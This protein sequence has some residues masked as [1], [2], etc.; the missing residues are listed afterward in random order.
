MALRQLT[1]SF[2]GAG[3][4]AEALCRRFREAG[5]RIGMIVSRDSAGGMKLAVDCGALWSPD[6]VFPEDTD[7]V[8]VAVPD[9]SVAGVLSSAST[10]EGTIIAHTAGSLGLEVF[11]AWMKNTGVFYPLQ[12]FTKGRRVEFGGLPFFIE[13]SGESTFEN[14]SRLSEA[15]GGR[16]F[17][18]DDE[19]RR[20][21]H[22]AA[23]FVNNFT[24]Y[25]LTAGKSI[26]GHAGLDFTL[27][28]PLIRETVDKA[29]AAGPE[30]S[31][32]GPAIRDDRGT[33]EKHIK[34]LSFSPE[35]QKLY[36]E[37]TE[38]ITAHYKK[39]EK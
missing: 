36:M 18:L 35:L 15:I 23:V 6:P 14:L 13:A 24:N 10:G 4:V 33:I 7:I 30:V 3:K 8:I 5:L 31:Q 19:Q 16:A 37:V 39:S 11:P 29:L 12:T 21:L 9:D 25:M 22:A 26:T 2:I 17:R 28:G 32:T 20:C 1:V 38:A 34:L 27:L